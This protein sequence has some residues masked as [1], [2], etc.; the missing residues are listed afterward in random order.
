M[1]YGE[2]GSLLIGSGDHYTIY[3]LKG[4]VIKS[5]DSRFNVDTMDR[6]RPSQQLDALHIQDF[7]RGI[8]D[9]KNVRGGV[10]DAHK[11]TLLCQLGNI[12]YRTKSVLEINPINGHV[13]DNLR[14][15][16]LWVKSYHEGFEPR[17]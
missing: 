17:I 7:F 12:A 5:E 11:S 2:K 3:D 9:G 13:R 4:N 14:A 8:T 1:F 10:E 15:R 16:E 6:R